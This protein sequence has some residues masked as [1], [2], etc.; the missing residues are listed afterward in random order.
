MEQYKILVINPGSTST[1]VAVFEELRPVLEM[2]LRHSEEELRPFATVIDQL[3]FRTGIV[4]DT[5]HKAGIAVGSLNAVIGRGGLLKPI[6]SGV[7]E[8]NSA[9][10]SDLENGAYGQHA[11]NLGALI[12]SRI[13]GTAGVPAFI[14]DPVVVDEMEQVARITGLPQIE[15]RSIFHAL[16]QKAVARLYA[17]RKGRL[18]EDINLVVAHMGGGISVGA[19]LKGRVVDIN[20]ALDGDGPFASERA[21]SL[22]AGD[23]VRLCFNG[24]H[25]EAELLKMLNGRGGLVAQLQT[26]DLRRVNDMIAGG[27]AKAELIRDAMCYNVGKCIGS[28]AAVLHGDVDAIILTGGIAHDQKVCD[29]IRMM[30]ENIAPVEVFPGENEMEALATNALRVLRGEEQGAIYS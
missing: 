19:H 25:T 27:D 20:N 21:G 10:K 22:P 7:Y 2:T 17:R 29:Y 11:S 15:R 16:N 8:V 24:R 5:L 1:K 9:M 28:M 26:N 12:A 18:Y 14:A 6:P 23:L 30:T 3:D 4:L 13:A